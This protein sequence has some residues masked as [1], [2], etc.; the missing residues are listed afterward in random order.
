MIGLAPDC[1]VEY[2]KRADAH[3]RDRDARPSASEEDSLPVKKEPSPRIESLELFLSWAI[4]LT[5]FTA[6]LL[7][8]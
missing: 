4:R 6:V 3:S 1:F 8:F 7:L 5:A 2:S